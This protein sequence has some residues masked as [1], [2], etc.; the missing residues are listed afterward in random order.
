M[1]Y[2]RVISTLSRKWRR[3]R[4][5]LSVNDSLEHDN[6]VIFYDAAVAGGTSWV[7]VFGAIGLCCSLFLASR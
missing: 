2:V 1:G 4:E 5:G 3:Q 7:A 6:P